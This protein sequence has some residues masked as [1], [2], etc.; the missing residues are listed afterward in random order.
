MRVKLVKPLALLAGLAMI[1]VAGQAAAQCHNGCAPPAPPSPPQ[2][3]KGPDMPG[4]GGYYGG[5]GGG[6]GDYGRGGGNVNVR[7]TVNVNVGG[8]AE[9]L[10]PGSFIG[11]GGGQTVFGGGYSN[12]SQTPGIPSNIGLNVETG[13]EAAMESFQASRSSTR[14]MI[15]QASCIDDK[16]VPHPASQVSGDRNVDGRYTGELYRCIAGTRLQYTVADYDGQIRING[17]LTTDC[18]KGEAL[19]HDGGQVSCRAQTQQ[20]DCNERS[21]LRRFGAGEKILTL[22]TTENYMAE[23][24][25]VRQARAT[26]Q[27]SMVFDGGVGGFVQ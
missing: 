1:S 26:H 15:I 2:H 12:W 13:Q 20:R 19:Y 24:Q 4:G 16:G 9:R 18:R 23:R 7:N 21:L 27:T 3:P 10:G 6:G 22:T 8:S 5:G 11:N 14:T 17:G 25:V